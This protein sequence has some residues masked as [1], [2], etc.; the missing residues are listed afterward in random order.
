[1]TVIS[2]KP[3]PDFTVRLVA[4]GIRPW[5]VPVR[6]LG[7]VLI[8]AQRLFNENEDIDD[9]SSD[10]EEA[11]A[12]GREKTML[13]LLGITSGSAVYQVSSTKPLEAVNRLTFLEKEISMPGQADWQANELSSI[14]ELSGIAKSF[15]C[16][17]EFCHPKKNKRQWVPI[18]TIHPDTFNKISATAFISGYT[19]VYARIERVGGV[20]Q[21]RCGIR[22]ASQPNKMI[23]CRIHSDE[24]VR[25]L[26]QHI[27]QNVIVAGN[28]TWLRR[29]SELCKME[30]SSFEPP[31]RGSIKEML[32]RVHAAG[33]NAWDAID[34]PDAVIA[35]M[36]S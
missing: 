33:G 29:T 8:A 19:S 7:R 9:T 1:M 36:R 2:K 20:V 16:I 4:K 31:K 12:N 30:I 11:D 35:E 18:A 5:A 13:R 25:N 21:K 22:L 3:I 15:G 34:D 26:G 6:V 32:Q 14:E 23:S 10:T 27:Y 17:I 28:A 24:L